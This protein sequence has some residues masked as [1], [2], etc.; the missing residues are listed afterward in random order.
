M[1]FFGVVSDF[2]E[3]PIANKNQPK[4]NYMNDMR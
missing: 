2:K 3:E 1:H 4:R